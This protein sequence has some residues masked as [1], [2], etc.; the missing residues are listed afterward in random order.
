MR[1]ERIWNRLARVSLLCSMVALATACSADI[2][3]YQEPFGESKKYITAF[4]VLNSDEWEI[5]TDNDA[6]L[7][8]VELGNQVSGEDINS[9]NGRV[10]FNYTID[11]TRNGVAEVRLNCFYPLEV[12]ELELFGEEESESKALSMAESTPE[13]KDEDFVSLLQNPAMPHEVSVGGGYINVNVCYPSV[14]NQKALDVVLYYDACSSS[15]D[16]AVLQLVGELEGAKSSQVEYRWYSFRITEEIA[17][18]IANTSTYSFYWCWWAEEGNHEAG[19]KE[20]TS[21]MNVCNS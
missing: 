16:S 6:R 1:K 4:G 12:K 11:R 7:H 13:W 3:M 15:D 17:A 18:M 8:I 20:Y 19:T 2:G 14:S 9:H 10:L 5:V 21:V